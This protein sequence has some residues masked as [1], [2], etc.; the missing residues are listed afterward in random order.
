MLFRSNRDN[1]EDKEPLFDA[2]D[3]VTICLRVYAEMVPHIVVRRDAC[4]A[5]AAKGFS[6]ATDLADYLVGKG[7]PFRDAHHVVGAVVGYAAQHQRDLAELSL[8]ELRRFS[9][10][11]EAD[12]H[13]HITLEASVSARKTY[14][15]T[16]PDQVRAAIA[17]A[18]RA[19][20]QRSPR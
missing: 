10:A 15:G 17:R 16:A 19:L 18:R 12:V 4:R 1:Q 7:L 13:Q 3:T 2:I 5:A 8:D 11:I 20:A 14:G 6:T 9:S